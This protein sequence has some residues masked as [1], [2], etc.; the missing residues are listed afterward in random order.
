[1]LVSSWGINASEVSNEIL[2]CTCRCLWIGKIFPYGMLDLVYGQTFN[3][4]SEVTAKLSHLLLLFATKY[5]ISEHSGDQRCIVSWSGE[6][7]FISLVRGQMKFYHIEIFEY[8]FT[9]LSILD[10]MMTLFI[11]CWARQE[12]KEP[13]N[14]LIDGCH[15]RWMRRSHEVP[16]KKIITGCSKMPMD[17]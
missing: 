6:Y 16:T 7:P 14:N 12:N 11:N 9:R 5:G 4:K 2:S 8:E 1:M 13:V 17:G 15:L 3:A 10:K